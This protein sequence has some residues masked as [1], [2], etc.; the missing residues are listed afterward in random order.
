MQRD[1]TNVILYNNNSNISFDNYVIEY[2]DYLFN[3]MFTI[4]IGLKSHYYFHVF[5]YDRV[6]L[7]VYW[8]FLLHAK[9]MCI[10]LHENE[11]GMT[12]YDCTQFHSNEYTYK[13]CNQTVEDK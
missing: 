5:H 3:F 6:S 9:G 12:T 4:L 13:R 7:F 8:F 2:F 11:N 10:I 1:K